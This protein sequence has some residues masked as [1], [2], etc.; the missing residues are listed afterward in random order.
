MRVRFTAKYDA[1][2]GL[3]QETCIVYEVVRGFFPP[4]FLFS[5]LSPLFLPPPTLLPPPS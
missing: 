4:L 2:L 3:V 1:S 5:P